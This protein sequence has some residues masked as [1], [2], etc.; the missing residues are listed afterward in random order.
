MLIRRSPKTTAGTLQDMA[1]PSAPALTAARLVVR[2]KPQAGYRSG[3]TTTLA[4][5]I[6]V[7][8]HFMVN[9]QAGALVPAQS[10]LI[11]ALALTRGGLGNVQLRRLLGADATHP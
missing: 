3:G 8:G 1:L 6:G 9:G 5:R 2:P 10:Q 11:L 4:L 7:L